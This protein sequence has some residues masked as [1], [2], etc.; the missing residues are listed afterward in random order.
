MLLLL[1]LLPNSVL[2][3]KMSLLDVRG[4][5]A[6]VISDDVVP[7]EVS[8]GTLSD[9]KTSSSPE[10]SKSVVP[11]TGVAPCRKPNFTFRDTSYQ[12]KLFNGNYQLLLKRHSGQVCYLMA[13]IKC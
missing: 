10:P 13:K 1:L 8:D 12:C 6:K 2:T 11:E 3:G 7:D 4:V 5:A 9:E